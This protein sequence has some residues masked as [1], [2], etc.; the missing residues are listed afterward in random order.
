MAWAIGSSS[1]SVGSSRISIGGYNGGGFL[2]FGPIGVNGYKTFYIYST[3]GGETWDQISLKFYGNERDMN[4]L[5]QNNP[6]YK[7]NFDFDSGDL[8]FIPQIETDTSIG[9]M[10]WSTIFAN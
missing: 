5:I 1:T 3:I 4:L 7:N 6:A 8:L 9:A 2:G 10:A